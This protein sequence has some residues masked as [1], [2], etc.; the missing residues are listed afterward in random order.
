MHYLASVERLFPTSSS[1]IR[2][3]SSVTTSTFFL[4]LSILRFF[5]C[6][7]ALAN[8]TH[9]IISHKGPT[10]CDVGGTSGRISPRQTNWHNNASL[11]WLER[12]SS[13]TNTKHKR[14]R[15][16]QVHFCIL[17]IHFQADLPH[18]FVVRR[19]PMR[20]DVP[21]P[22]H[23]QSPGPLRRPTALHDRAGG[24]QQHEHVFL[25]Q[26]Q[27]VVDGDYVQGKPV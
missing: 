8:V 27:L 13:Y 26:I 15:K 7:L 9:L 19:G 21:P 20:A 16:I 24:L 25:L 10:S 3:R 18:H 22:F 6:Q 4:R 12:Q 1:Q 2:L 17:I 11:R 14:T 23:R 5:L